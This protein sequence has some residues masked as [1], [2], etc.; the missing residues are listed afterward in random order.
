MSDLVDAWTNQAHNCMV[1]AYGQTGTGKTHTMFGT[2]ESLKSDE[3]HTDWG[4]FPRVVSTQ[5]IAGKA[6]QFASR[7]CFS[8]AKN[9]ATTKLMRSPCC[10]VSEVCGVLWQQVDTAL[11]RMAAVKETC[12]APDS[13]YSMDYV[14][15]A[16]AIEFYVGMASDLL[17][18]KCPVIIDNNGDP[19]GCNYTIIEKV[20]ES[21]QPHKESYT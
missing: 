15:T 21:T 12:D 7:L 9:V 1:F 17:Y 14:L 20:H 5:R 2:P 10:S 19:V 16:S 4:I 11:K 18:E 8:F 13:Q 6:S 3:P